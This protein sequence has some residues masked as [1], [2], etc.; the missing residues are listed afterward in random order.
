MSES[1]LSPWRRLPLRIPVVVS[2]A[3]VGGFGIGISEYVTLR[4]GG[5]VR[6][7]LLERL[8]FHAGGA[9]GV[10]VFYV[11]G[12]LVLSSVGLFLFLKRRSARR[13]ALT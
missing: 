7:W 3:G 11:V 5:S 9:A 2:G 8:A 4:S 1:H 6:L 12:G 13:R 10:L